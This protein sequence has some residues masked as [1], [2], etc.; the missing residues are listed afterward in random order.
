[1]VC[2]RTVQLFNPNAK[3]NMPSLVVLILL[4]RVEAK[5]EHSNQLVC[6]GQLRMSRNV[7][8]WAGQFLPRKK[9]YPKTSNVMTKAE[10]RWPEELVLIS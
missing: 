5:L 9:Y 10:G 6:D 8:G 1:M 7:M 4:P 2:L 3:A